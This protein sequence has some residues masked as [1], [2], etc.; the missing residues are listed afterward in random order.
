MSAFSH[1]NVSSS[2]FPDVSGGFALLDDAQADG[3]A[4]RLYSGLQQVLQCDDASTWQQF[5]SET[6]TALQKNQYAVA[7]LSY[8]IGVHLQ[9]IPTDPDLSASAATQ[10]SQILIFRDCQHLQREDVTRFLAQQTNVTDVAGVAQLRSNIDEPAFSAA[11]HTIRDYI[12]AGDTYQV[13]YTYRLHF[14]AYG[15]PAALYQRLR[16]RQPVPYGALICLPHG[17]AVLSMS[18]ELFVRHYR[19]HLQARPM[20]GTAAATGDAV[21]DQSRATALSADTK[22]RAENLM[23]VDLLRND[24]GKIATTGSVKVSQLFE[25]TRYSSVLQMTSTIDAQLQPQLALPDIL[26]ALFP[27]GSITGAPKRRTM[28]IIQELEPEPR[29]LYTGAIGWFDPPADHVDAEVV[30]ENA[31]ESIPAIPVAPSVRAAIGDFCLSV[32][33]RTLQLEAPSTR[34]GSQ[35]RRGVMGV[36]AGIVYDSVASEEFAEC[37]LKAKFLTGLPAQ[38]DLFE[39]MHATREVGCRYLDRHLL[40]LQTSARYFGF[41]VDEQQIRQTLQQFCHDLPPQTAYRLRLSLDVEG[42]TSLSSGVLLPLAA[43]QMRV[44]LSSETTQSDTLLLRHKTSVRSQYDR[45]WQ[46]AEQQGAFD[47]LFFNETGHLTEG[48]R[49]NVLLRFGK[50]WLTPPLSDGVL[51]G[52]MRSV[53]MDDAALGLREQHLTRRDVLQADQILLCNSLRGAFTVTLQDQAS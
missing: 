18:P 26:H 5:W 22:N 34:D 47:M 14:D 19:G 20:K 9:G 31:A 44:L 24:L 6:Q 37:R 12:T 11:I 46:A 39:T 32:P 15:S 16:Q 45:A 23:I 48:G 2:F 27:C 41:V 8:D 7:L 10:P 17:E 21:Q 3:A 49:S 25:V 28:E 1:M 43:T 40:R 33:I 30:T 53:L 51:P 50:Q 4:S 42:K 36:G 13:N 52:V 38:F 29:G 35:I